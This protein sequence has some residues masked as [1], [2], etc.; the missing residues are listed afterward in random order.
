M[1]FL[2]KLKNFLLGGE[3]VLRRVASI[4]GAVMVLYGFWHFVS[5]GQ[6]PPMIT[7]TADPPVI[8]ACDERA[9]PVA[10]RLVSGLALMSCEIAEIRVCDFTGQ[11]KSAEDSSHNMPAYVMRISAEIDGKRLPFIGNGRGDMAKEAA[12]DSLFNNLKTELEERGLC[13]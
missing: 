11:S 2:L 6:K 8:T 9:E 1:N 3:S 10:A 4:A 12:F 7:D 13:G 5:G